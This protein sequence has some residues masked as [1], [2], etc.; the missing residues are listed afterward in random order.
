MPGSVGPSELGV[1]SQR[2]SAVLEH[3]PHDPADGPGSA[4]CG[5]RDIRLAEEADE[6]PDLSVRLYPSKR[7]G[8]VLASELS[9]SRRPGGDNGMKALETVA[10][11]TGRVAARSADWAGGE[12]GG[13]ALC[14]G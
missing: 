2:R 5:L 11:W 14:G 8:R 1:S 9:L 3:E 6:V 12:G 4:D 13:A 7:I 10:I